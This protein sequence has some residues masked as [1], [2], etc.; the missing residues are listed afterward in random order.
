VTC[1]AP[2]PFMIGELVVNGNTPLWRTLGTVRISI[3]G[4]LFYLSQFQGKKA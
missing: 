4:F 3:V 2:H 1:G